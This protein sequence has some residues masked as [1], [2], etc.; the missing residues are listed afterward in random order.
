LSD[1]YNLGTFFRLDGGLTLSRALRELALPWGGVEGAP[2]FRPAVTASLFIDFWVFDLHPFGFH[3][4][5]LALHVLNSL[6][7]A[8]LVRLLAPRAGHGPAVLAGLFFGLH[9]ATTETAAWIAARVDSLSTFFYLLSM[10]AYCRYARSPSARW[11]ALTFLAAGLALF[12]KES[13]LTLPLVLLTVALIARQRSVLIGSVI[14]LVIGCST[15][16]LVVGLSGSVSGAGVSAGNALH[17]ARLLFPWNPAV[18]PGVTAWPFHVLFVAAAAYLLLGVMGRYRSPALIG[19]VA[20][21]FTYALASLL[22]TEPSTYANSRYAYMPLSALTVVLFAG[23]SLPR[24]RRFPRLGSGLLALM[25]AALALVAPR[26]V[27][28]WQEAGR[29]ARDVIAEG[30]KILA[31]RPD[32]WTILANLPRR[33]PRGPYVFMDGNAFVFRSPFVEPSFSRVVT[34]READE[35]FLRHPWVFETVAL[36][37][38]AIY[39]W[40]PA[41]RS[42]HPVPVAAARP[43][44]PPLDGDLPADGGRFSPEFFREFRVEDGDGPVRVRMISPFGA[45]TLHAVPHHDRGYAVGELGLNLMR[46]VSEVM[47]EVEVLMVF[48][49]LGESGVVVQRRGPVSAWLVPLK[50]R[51]RR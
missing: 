31:E 47:G 6:L 51:S 25:C 45:G 44:P 21:F 40:V 23:A 18:A 7:V 4:H 28:A 20:L 22:P 16:I 26:S 29:L 48:E 49:R 46:H 12:S 15:R 50:G 5:N 33:A 19:P 24:Y 39:T 2:F 43:T 41:S 35:F 14:L 36:A 11:L 38:G 32:R 30:R 13:G 8:V 3:L 34:T 37:H 42:F 10:A 17:L 27:A 1:D 9:P